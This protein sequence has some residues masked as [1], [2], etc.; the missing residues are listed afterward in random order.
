MCN[1]E[2]PGKR[3]GHKYL[4]VVGPQLRLSTFARNKRGTTVRKSTYTDMILLKLTSASIQKRR[5][6][7]RFQSV[8]FGK[9]TVKTFLYKCSNW[10]EMNPLDKHE[11]MSVGYQVKQNVKSL[12]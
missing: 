5:N 12:S 9:E 6:T 11:V 10:G 8:L 3:G 1:N 7:P 2:Y 4:L